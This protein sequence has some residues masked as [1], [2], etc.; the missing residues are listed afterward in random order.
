MDSQETSIHVGIP[1]SIVGAAAV[2]ASPSPTFWRRI[3]T[4]IEW[5]GERLNPLLVK[6]VRQSLKSRQFSITFTAVLCLS[7]LW[8]IAG[9]ARLGPGVSYG[10]NGPEI[11]FG[12]YLILAFPLILIVPYSAFRSLIAEREDNTYELVAITTLRPRQIVAGKLGSA[13]AQ[14]AVYFSAVAP[15]LAFTYLLR[16]IDV[17]TIGWIMFY[18]FL[19][20]LGFSL[21]ALLLATIAK[22]KHWQVMLAVVIIVVLFWAFTTAVGIC[23]TRLRFAR[24]PF[25]NP[26]FWL[27]NA[28]FLS[29]YVSTFALLY[30]AAAAQ[31]TFNSENRSTPLRWA[32][33]AQQILWVGWMGFAVFHTLTQN[34]GAGTNRLGCVIALIVSTIYWFVMGSFMTGEATE[35]SPRVKRRLPVSVLGRA[36]LTWFNPGPGTGYLFAVCNVAAVALLALAG[37][38]YDQRTGGPT[39]VG[40]PAASLQLAAVL[41][42]IGYLTIFLGVGNLLLRLLR[43]FTRVN[44]SA[45]VLVN[46]LLVMAGWGIPAIIDP[47]DIVNSTY[48]LRHVTD[49]IWSCTAPLNLH[50]YGPQSDELLII[51]LPTAAAVFLFNLVYIVPE[52]QQGRTAPPSRVTEE[53]QLLSAA[54]QPT[55][56]QPTSPWQ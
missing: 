55:L 49:P 47:Y 17:P 31:L 5:A 32:M 34:G 14:M 4:G 12:Y 38:W 27:E 16:G 21:C 2:D 15:C 13:V 28:I 44:L 18:T 19:A 30:L 23:H 26:E 6:E 1:S 7:W 40:V 39:T 46:V 51:I 53:D 48:N 36:F 41:L 22:E 25:T 24:L 35:L 45:A 50:A 33:L 10:A 42:L 11:F 3:G 56:P 52:I 29:F 20:S 9:I 43:K 54:S 8:S 37:I